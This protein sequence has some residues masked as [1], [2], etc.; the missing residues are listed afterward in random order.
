MQGEGFKASAAH[1][2]HLPLGHLNGTVCQ[3]AASG[4]LFSACQPPGYQGEGFTV[5]GEQAERWAW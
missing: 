5:G 3:A 2:S 4:S 1:D